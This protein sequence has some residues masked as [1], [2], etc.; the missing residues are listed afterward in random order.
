[1]TAPLTPPPHPQSSS[2]DGTAQD[3]TADGAT[4]HGDSP[5][6][7]GSQAAERHGEGATAGEPAGGS[8]RYAPRSALRAYL[9]DGPGLRTE[10]RQAALVLGALTAAGLLL[11]LLWVWLAPRV[12]L[13]GEVADG[14]W[15]AFLADIE[16][17]Q[18]V[19]AAG[20]FTLLAAGFGLLSAVPVF[21]LARR[22]G[23]PVVVG[24]CLG[25][26]LGSLVAWQIGMSL[27]PTSDV[28]AHARQVGEGVRFDAP[29][30]LHAIS[31]LAAWPVVA[32]LTHLTLTAL[33]VPR[34]DEESGGDLRDD[35][36]DPAPT[37]SL[38][39]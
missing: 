4:V 15:V 31:A 17:E 14:R 26:L 39:K 34:E 23:V 3:G 12:P 20:T 2:Q 19:G 37:V 16:G 32:L 10:L 1:M 36:D 11:G 24:L 28:A 33:L 18:S 25:G 29:L 27:G 22:G 35:G 21:L 6:P 38:Q 30:E 5:A 7:G 8:H 9:E 13:V